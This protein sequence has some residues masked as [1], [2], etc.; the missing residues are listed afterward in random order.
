MWFVVGR[1]Q[2]QKCPV[3]G[4]GLGRGLAVFAL[5][6]KVVLGSQSPLSTE[7]FTT[8]T[9]QKKQSKHLYTVVSN[10]HFHPLLL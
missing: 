7:I 10:L 6:A 5:E 4:G 2:G 9:H 1:N 3:E 8:N